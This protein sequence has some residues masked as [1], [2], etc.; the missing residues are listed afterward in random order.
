MKKLIIFLMGLISISS[1]SAQRIVTDETDKFT[2]DRIIETST[3]ETGRPMEAHYKLRQVNDSLFLCIRIKNIKK[4]D[5]KENIAPLMLL[6]RSGDKI[7]LTGEIENM[8]SKERNHSIHWGAGISSGGAKKVTDVLISAYIPKDILMTLCNDD[9]T[10]IRISIGNTNIDKSFEYM[11]SY[12][13]L[14][15]MFNLM[16]ELQ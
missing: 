1:L 9:V 6:M 4:I 5:I 8:F 11:Y 15:K 3:L 12:K 7:N 10:D 16:Q 2:G 13:R 14:R